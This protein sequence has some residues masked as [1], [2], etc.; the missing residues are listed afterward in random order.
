MYRI[1]LLVLC[2]VPVWTLDF[3]TPGKPINL[4]TTYNIKVELTFNL[5][6]TSEFELNKLDAALKLILIN[7]QPQ[8]EAIHKLQSTVKLYYSALKTNIEKRKN[9]FSNIAYTS[10]TPCKIIYSVISNREASDFLSQL[11]YLIKFVPSSSTL[12]QDYLNN[13][14]ATLLQTLNLLKNMLHL[15]NQ[16][17]DDIE[18]FLTGM[19]TDTTY[20]LI[21]EAPCLKPNLRENITMHSC[22][23]T[24]T[25]LAVILNVVQYSD[26]NHIFALEATPFHRYRLNLTNVFLDGGSLINIVCNQ[27]EFSDACQK[28]PF[29]P[30]CTNALAKRSITQILKNC[31]FIDDSSPIPKITEQGILVPSHSTINPLPI[32][33]KIPLNKPYLLKTNTDLTITSGNKQ[34]S[35]AKNA[36]ISQIDEFYLSE[37]D[38]DLYEDFFKP[39]EWYEF[40][41]FQL[42]AALLI[43]IA[44]FT[45]I[46]YL[47]LRKTKHAKPQNLQKQ[48]VTFQLPPL[49]PRNHLL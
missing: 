12:T 41:I 27:A 36:E 19:I 44:I 7:V 30:D 17:N 49:T 35:F 23:P 31:P 6:K 10:N 11:Q 4:P 38:Q 13:Y 8:D 15:T 42:L 28:V 43:A 14:Y 39:E 48:T 1:L 2:V 22:I 33:L 5:L 45:P 9:I 21:Q 32:S 37:K 40:L 26:N 25:G 20:P 47:V 46:L 34:F 16:E 18:M 29:K 3:Y 24:P